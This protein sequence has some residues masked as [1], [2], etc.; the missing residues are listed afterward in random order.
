MTIKVKKGVIYSC[1]EGLED[2]PIGAIFDS[3]TEEEESTMEC[4]FEALPAIKTFI[5]DVNS[6]SFKPRSVVKGLEQILDRYAV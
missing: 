6:G 1:E 3:A 4:A 5:D 2:K